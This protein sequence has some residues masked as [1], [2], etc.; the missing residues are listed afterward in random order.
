MFGL[1][2]PADEQTLSALQLHFSLLGTDCMSAQSDV[3]ASS[4][5]SLCS[6]PLQ[7]AILHTIKLHSANRH[8]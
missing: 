3:V 1:W 5:C 8:R 6:S 4:C 2:S 7:E